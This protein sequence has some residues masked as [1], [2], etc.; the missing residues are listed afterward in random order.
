M[1]FGVAAVLVACAAASAAAAKVVNPGAVTMRPAAADSTTPGAAGTVTRAGALSFAQAGIWPL[2]VAE[3]SSPGGSPEV[4][5]WE[6]RA[7]GT[8]DVT[9]RINPS[10]GLVALDIASPVPLRYS[11]AGTF[12]GLSF[13]VT[14][15]LEGGDPVSLGPTQGTLTALE[16]DQQTG[17][18]PVA[19]PIAAAL[20]IDEDADCA[21]AGDPLIIISGGF[22]IGWARGQVSDLTEYRADL[23]FKPVLK[24]PVQVGTRRAD[25]MTGTKY[26]EEIR[27][28]GGNDTLRGLGGRD[29]LSGGAGNDRITGGAGKDAVDAGAGR[30]TVYAR[31]GRAET[32]RCG[33]GRDRVKAD[34]SDTLIGCE[35]RI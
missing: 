27:G 15:D 9:G 7:L 23:A 5:R 34:K 6:I 1:T 12:L 10:T 3:G 22:L 14:C 19:A 20:G 24:A 11:A 16:Y 13:T 4:S 29:K 2:L 26:D 33:S 8:G 32:V 17:V 31:D 30:D 21:L 28:L 25:V 35:R 18:G